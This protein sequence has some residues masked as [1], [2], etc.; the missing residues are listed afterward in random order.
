MN[1]IQ[2]LECLLMDSPEASQVILL[3][4]SHPKA[5]PRTKCEGDIFPL[6]FISR[7]RGEAPRV[8]LG[9]VISCV[10]TKIIILALWW[11]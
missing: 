9:A 3:I 11:G 8:F 10:E 6:N 5:L 2:S 7:I 1:S 4:F